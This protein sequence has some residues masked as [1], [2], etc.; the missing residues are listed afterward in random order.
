MAIRKRLLATKDG[1][2]A[3]LL[4]DCLEERLLHELIY[5]YTVWCIWTFSSKR[6]PSKRD[7]PGSKLEISCAVDD[8]DSPRGWRRKQYCWICAFGLESPNL[9]YDKALGKKGVVWSCSCNGERID[10]QCVRNAPT[11]Q[12]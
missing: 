7:F 5:Q 10:V 1:D 4:Q 6:E 2:F 3:R 12:A 11:E 8:G 9:V